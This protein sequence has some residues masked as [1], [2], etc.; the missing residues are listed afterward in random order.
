MPGDGHRRP[1]DNSKKPEKGNDQRYGMGDDFDQP[2]S[3]APKNGDGSY[4]NKQRE[5]TA[6]GTSQMPSTFD[7]S[8]RF[9]LSRH[10]REHI[11]SARVMQSG[12]HDLTR[13]KKSNIQI[14]TSK[15][16]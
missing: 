2:T 8:R 16:N 7:L 14:P 1:K 12:G 3:R 11:E 5:L 4:A 6:H 13:Q 10:A 9:C 15:T